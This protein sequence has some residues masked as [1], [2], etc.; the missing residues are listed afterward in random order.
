[1]RPDLD[2]FSML[3]LLIDIST[4]GLCALRDASMFL[5][6][7]LLGDGFVSAKER[8]RSGAAF[9]VFRKSLLVRFV[10]NLIY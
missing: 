4:Y 9:K 7:I 6:G 5:G 2:F 1:L 10:A 3:R 8:R